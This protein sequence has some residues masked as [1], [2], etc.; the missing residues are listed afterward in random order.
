MN[1]T[2]RTYQTPDFDRV[3]HLLWQHFQPLNRDGNWLQ[4]AWEYMHFHPAFDETALSRIGIWE[5]DGALVAVAHYES[6]LGEAFFQVHP[7]F[8][9][10]KPNLLAYAEAHLWN[11]NEQGRRQLQVYCNDFDLELEALLTSRGYRL[12]PRFPRPMSAFDI[13]QPFPAIT[14]PDGFRLKSLADDNNLRQV[15]RVLWRGF[16]HP[17]EPPE[18]EL[19]DRRKMQSGPHFR[20]DLTIV[21]ESPGGDFVSFCGMWF[22]EINRIAYVEPVATDPDFRRL[23]LGKAAVWEGIR[24]C[25]ALGATMAFVGSDLPFYG[26][27]GFRKLFETRCWVKIW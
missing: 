14:L 15:H 8:T 23:G 19:D 27:I 26:A 24:R 22:D 13:P 18:K 5:S 3:S 25:G 16:N 6:N 9:H 11:E 10:L 2:Q 1:I 21:V 4:A 20:H 7:Q 17:G 12:E